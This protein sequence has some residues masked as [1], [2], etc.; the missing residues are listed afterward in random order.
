MNY[1]RADFSPRFS[2]LAPR[3]LKSAIQRTASEFLLL[4]SGWFFMVASDEFEL[5]HEN[6]AR[7]EVSSSNG[8]ARYRLK[9]KTTIRIKSIPS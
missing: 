5:D 3:G 6:P 4:T 7:F 9:T 8:L 1:R 2:L